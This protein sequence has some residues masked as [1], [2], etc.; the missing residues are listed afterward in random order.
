MDNLEPLEK[1]A[2][3]GVE[4]KWLDGSDDSWI[5]LARDEGEFIVFLPRGR[6]LLF[7]FYM[8]ASDVR[9][10]GI[11]QETPERAAIHLQDNTRYMVHSTAKSAEQYRECA[12]RVP[13]KKYRR[14]L[15]DI[16]HDEA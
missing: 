9:A 1:L 12:D 7:E 3:G 8:K 14:M 10:V 13:M 2:H 16:F 6:R 5:Y 4:L 15:C 11:T